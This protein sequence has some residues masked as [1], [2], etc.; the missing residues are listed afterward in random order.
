MCKHTNTKYAISKMKQ[1]VNIHNSAVKL[2]ENHRREMERDV[3]LQ[4]QG[5]KKKPS[6]NK[7]VLNINIFL[8]M[9]TQRGCD[10]PLNL[11][12]LLSGFYIAFHTLEISAFKC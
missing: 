11:S 7:R 10:G 9:N 8:A 6:G 5:N 12:F 1:M 2:Q 3:S 4:G